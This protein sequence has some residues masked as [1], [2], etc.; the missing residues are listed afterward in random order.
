MKAK[1]AYRLIVTRGGLAPALLG[2]KLAH[3]GVLQGAAIAGDEH[4][5]D[6][7]IVRGSGEMN[8]GR[9]RREVACAGDRALQ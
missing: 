4:A 2:P 8:R 5:L 9:L 1:H 6:L 3:S 7:R